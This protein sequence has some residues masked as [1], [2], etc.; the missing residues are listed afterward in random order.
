MDE[1]ST[2]MRIQRHYKLSANQAN[3]VA[4]SNY[5]FRLGYDRGAEKDLKLVRLLLRPISR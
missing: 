1:A 5:G 3:I 2:L 4:Q